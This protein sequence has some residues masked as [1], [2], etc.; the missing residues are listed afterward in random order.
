[1]SSEAKLVWRATA[2]GV[3]AFISGY[4]ARMTDE[5]NGNV[6]TVGFIFALCIAAFVLIMM[7]FDTE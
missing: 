3:S 7:I 4:F 6:A 2:L 1:M 5:G